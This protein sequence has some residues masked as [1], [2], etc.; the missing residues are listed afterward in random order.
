M[1]DQI[2]SERGINASKPCRDDMN[3][4]F[5]ALAQQ[6]RPKT[7]ENDYL[8]LNMAENKLLLPVLQAKLKDVM[9][10][11][12]SL[13][14]WVTSYGD[15]NGHIEFRQAIAK[16]MNDT[17]WNGLPPINPAQLAVQAGVSAILDMIGFTL[18][19][20]KSA[21]IIPGPIYP[22]FISD[23]KSRAD[24]KLYV[25]DCEEN[26]DVPT[27]ALLERQYEQCVQ[28]NCIP[29][30][31]LLCQPCNPNGIIYTY[32]TMRDIIE[33]AIGKGLHVVSDEIYGNSLFSHKVHV[34]AGHVM[35]A[36][37]L[38]KHPG[39]ELNPDNYLTDKVHIVMGL[40]K[41]FN[42]S[43]LRVGVL[44]SHCKELINAFGCMGYFQCNSNLNQYIL[45][46]MLCDRQWVNTYLFTSRMALT[47]CFHALE[48][49]IS[50]CDKCVI[51]PCD[52]TLMCW[53]DFSAYLEPKYV[54]TTTN[55]D[56]TAVDKL[57][58]LWEAERRLWLDLFENHHILFTLGK[59]C[60]G[61]KPGFF[62][63]TFAYPNIHPGV[64]DA[65]AE[66]TSVEMINQGVNQMDLTEN[67]DWV[68]RGDNGIN[69][70]LS[71]DML[72]QIGDVTI[73]M[74][75]LKKRLSLWVNSL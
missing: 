67:A 19:E 18:C 5:I 50:V 1:S 59:H 70:D 3:E 44:Y 62:R 27:S 51:R 33:W 69:L 64:T 71:K 61:R 28:E 24:V 73:A 68:H 48:D 31:L 37:H 46:Q 52:G 56:A 4:F 55:T 49:A 2:L 11:M 58:D 10:N 14:D 66:D 75:E 60:I 47:R 41:D 6:Y 13:P 35:R 34:S 12:K 57:D 32:D 25:A 22:A 54:N 72:L 8:I 17:A 40:S 38:E 36:L 20:P 65:S 9:N 15:S 63:I 29:R 42:M 53:A 16:M 45:T 21:V 7:N 23:F 39:S 43:G 74:K 30:M 26:G